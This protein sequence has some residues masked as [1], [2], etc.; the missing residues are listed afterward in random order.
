MSYF[1]GVFDVY[2][3]IF[4]KVECDLDVKEVKVKTI[5]NIGSLVEDKNVDNL[6][7]DVPTLEKLGIK[8]FFEVAIQVIIAVLEVKVIVDFSVLLFLVVRN[9]MIISVVELNF[10]LWLLL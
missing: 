7:L 2:I 10:L 8:F 3:L 6:V 4:I 5:V 1:V 9:V